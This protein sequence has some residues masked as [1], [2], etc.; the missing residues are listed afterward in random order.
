MQKIIEIIANVAGIAGA[1]ICL[2]AGLLRLAGNYY[3]AGFEAPTLYNIGIG[4]MV[5]SSMLKL[6]ILLRETRSSGS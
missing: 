6:E 1:L 3:L 4:L 2:T 5:F